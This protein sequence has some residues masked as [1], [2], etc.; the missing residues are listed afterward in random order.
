MP[1]LNKQQNDQPQGL[2]FDIYER[3]H[4]T[5]EAAGIAELEE[6]ELLPRIQVVTHGDHAAL[7]GHL[8]L[9]GVYRTPEQITSELHH[10]I[11]VEITIPLNR[12]GDW[13]IS[14]SRLKILMWT[15]SLYVV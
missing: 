7:R 10:L 5:E 3:I 6:I 2:R 11:P 8:L 4:L 13:K 1:S 9:E 12:V 15:C 14:L